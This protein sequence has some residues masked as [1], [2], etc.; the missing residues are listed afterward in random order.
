MTIRFD[1]ADSPEACTKP[2]ETYEDDTGTRYELEHWSVVP[3]TIPSVTREV[4][5]NVLY[6]QVEGMTTLPDTIEVETSDRGRGQT[7]TV[8]CQM[9]EQQAVREEWQDG[10]V[11]TV[12]FHTYEAGYYQLADR[13]I[14]YNDERPE[15]EGCEALL[16]ELVKVPPEDYRITHVQWAGEVYED[17]EGNQCRDAAAFGQKRI[18][19]YQ[20][21]YR[22]TAVFPAKE[23]WQTVAV[24]RLPEPEIGRAHV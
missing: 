19:D 5:E 18:R 23:G 17:E 1:T 11:V 22:G 14:P 12:T 24:Y 6:D 3:V 7:I 9:E 16:L 10:F 21:T 4:E 15:L 13:L 20:V 2:E 8:V